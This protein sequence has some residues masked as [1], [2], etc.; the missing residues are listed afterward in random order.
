MR[1]KKSVHVVKKSRKVRFVVESFLLRHVWYLTQFRQRTKTALAK[2][3]GSD[4]PAD[5]AIQVSQWK[6]FVVEKGSSAE[7]KTG[8][9]EKS[10]RKRFYSFH[11]M[12]EDDEVKSA[13]GKYVDP[14]SVAD[15][16]TEEND[17]TPTHRRKHSL[18]RLSSSFLRRADSHEEHVHDDLDPCLSFPDLWE[19]DNACHDA[20]REGYTQNPDTTGY[21]MHSIAGG[22]GKDAIGSPPPIPPRRGHN[23]A[24]SFDAALLTTHPTS[25]R[26]METSVIRD[27]LHGYVRHHSLAPLPESR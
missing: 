10:L 20:T 9:N 2:C 24:V 19:T 4:S 25:D 26:E 13:G 14:T 27:R 3:L 21:G 15:S 5:Y 23:R 8:G 16:A 1:K 6:A 22:L 11:S 12:N 7:E 17:H 18:M